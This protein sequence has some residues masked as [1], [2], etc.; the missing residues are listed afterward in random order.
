MFYVLWLLFFQEYLFLMSRKHFL[1]LFPESSHHFLLP[2]NLVCIFVFISCMEG[3][4][5]FSAFQL[6]FLYLRVKFHKIHWS[7]CTL[8]QACSYKKG[9]YKC[10]IA[11]GCWV[12]G[13]WEGLWKNFQTICLLL[14]YLQSHFPWDQCIQVLILV[15]SNC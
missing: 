10:L 8:A 2:K 13:G 7:L 11:A 12:G 14:S 5:C 1:H 6:I 15:I 9:M 3:C 4:C